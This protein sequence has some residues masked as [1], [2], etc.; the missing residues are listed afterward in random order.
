MVAVL[1]DRRLARFLDFPLEELWAN[2]CKRGF[3]MRGAAGSIGRWIIDVSIAWGKSGRAKM[4]AANEGFAVVQPG[5]LG[6]T[7][8]DTLLGILEGQI[9]VTCFC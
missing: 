1:L 3:A 2:L 7:A 6:G 8:V 5:P 4:L 9:F